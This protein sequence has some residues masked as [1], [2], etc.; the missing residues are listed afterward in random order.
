[1]DAYD[2]LE[3]ESRQ[4]RG[5]RDFRMRWDALQPVEAVNRQIQTELARF[6]QTKRITLATLTKAGARVRITKP[7][8]VD[9]AFASINDKGA[10]TAIKYRPTGGSSHDSVAEAG[11]IWTRPI[12]LG[13]RDALGWLIA[14]GETDGMRLHELVGD[15][16]GVMILPAGAKAFKR[17]W[18]DVIPRGATI[19]L[20]HDADPDGDEGAEKAAKILAGQ[21]YRIR[22]PVDRT[23]WCDWAGTSSD[24]ATLIRDAMSSAP[25]DELGAE[26]WSEFRDASAIEAPYLIEGLWPEG[27]VVFIAA[28]PKAGK[29]WVAL[30]IAISIATGAPWLGYTV[31]KVEPTLYIALEGARAKIRA[32]IGCLARGMGIDPNSEELDGLHVLYKPKGFNLSNE[33]WARRIITKAEAIGARIIIVDTLRSATTV[34]ESNEGAGDIGGLLKLLSPLTSSGC[35]IAFLHHYVKLTETRQQRAAADRMSGSGALRGHMDVGIF[36]TNAEFT[37][38]KRRMRIEIE[39]RDDVAPEP[40]GVRIAGEG[41][42][43]YGGLRYEDIATLEIDDEVLGES[44]V[45]AP[46]RAIAEWIHGLPTQRATPK[47]I[48]N[49]FDITERTLRAR[50]ELLKRAGIEYVEFGR[51]THY[52]VA[53]T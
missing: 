21:T 41:T 26:V 28:D 51:L 27:A 11:S 49:Q 22:P 39:S 48:R 29:T 24:F 14:E 30:S 10:V 42:A 1:M 8:S 6:C 20:C 47:E 25:G 4:P 38:D 17:E 31:P 19:G 53:G 33:D 44:E 43:Q 23:D 9:L 50:R 46:A 52:K 45:K 37:E 2:R 3:R 32:R 34:R 36:I 40:F 16:A 5:T 35:S 15:H 13:R 7:G 12:I 18:I